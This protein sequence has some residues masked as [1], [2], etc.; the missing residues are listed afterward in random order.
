MTQLRLLCLLAISFVYTHV[1]SAQTTADSLRIVVTTTMA[2]AYDAMYANDH[3]MAL[4]LLDELSRKPELHAYRQQIAQ[5]QDSV[6][7]SYLTYTCRSYC[8]DALRWISIGNYR[9]GIRAFKAARQYAQ[10]DVEREHIRLALKNTRQ[11]RNKRLLSSNALGAAAILGD[12]FFEGMIS[13]TTADYQTGKRPFGL[14]LTE[15]YGNADA[16]AR[17]KRSKLP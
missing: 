7:R 6:Q 12:L 13:G 5:A 1:M 9:K 14:G 4:A 3:P 10:T 2:R 11:A 8:Q 16:R 15:S 17:A